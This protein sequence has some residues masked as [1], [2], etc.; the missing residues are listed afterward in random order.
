MD[1]YR[2]RQPEVGRDRPKA[3]VVLLLQPRGSVS[4][5]VLSVSFGRDS[6]VSVQVI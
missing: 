2:R 1:C 4:V 6:G 5:Q 3:A